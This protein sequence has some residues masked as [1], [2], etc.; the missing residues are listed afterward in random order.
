VHFELESTPDRENQLVAYSVAL[1]LWYESGRDKANLEKLIAVANHDPEMEAKLHVCLNPP[2]PSKEKLEHQEKLAK[3][4]RQHEEK[5]RQEQ[6]DRQTWIKRLQSDP[7]KLRE[8]SDETVESTFPDLYWLATELEEHSEQGNSKWGVDQWE[9]LVDEFGLE[10]A[11]A[12]RDGLM[13]YWRHFCPKLQS[14][15]NTN[16]VPNGLIVGMVGLAVEARTKADWARCLTQEEA[17]LAARYATHELNGFPLWLEELLRFHPQAVDGILRKEFLWE[18][19]LAD[20][21]RSEPIHHMLAQ[22]RYTELKSLKERYRP[23]IFQFL[24]NQE[25]WRDQTLENALSI[26]LQWDEL[27]VQAFANLAKQRQHATDEDDRFL[28][29]LVAWLCVDAGGALVVLKKWLGE[30]AEEIGG[31]ESAIRFCGAMEDHLSIRF[32]SRHQDF[33]RVEVLKELVPL[34]YQHIRIEDDHVH[35]GGYTPDARDRAES[36]RDRLLNKVCDTPGRLAFE[37]LMDFS[38]I[39]PHEKLRERML[40]LARHR[41][42]ED[43]EFLPWKSADV[44]AFA[45]EAEKCPATARELFDLVCSRL[46]DIKYDLEE[47]DNSNAD[48]LQQLSKETQLRNWLSDRLRKDARGKYSIAPEE[49]LADGKR[50]DIRVHCQKIDAPCVIELKISDEWTFKRHMERLRNQLVA[51]YLRD[52][53][54]RFGVFLLVRKRRPYWVSKQRVFFPDLVI[55]VQDEADRIVQGRFDLEGI[56]VIGIDLMKRGAGGK[57]R[58]LEQRKKIPQ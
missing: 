54:S 6:I 36:M 33:E 49:E 7:Q 56:R 23:V 18:F 27:D 24:Q 37:T 16:S 15:D 43:A 39:L 47:G 9:S 11:E 13:A 52:T 25:P 14:E 26:V 57:I 4:K 34:M 30:G 29:W 46:D 53:R 12:A 22:I 40:V 1:S 48:I 44:V 2:P 28:T 31:K 58:R 45:R 21:A 19:G 32:G 42:A 41:A 17:L 10:V 5:E 35:E 20:G 55:Q 38:R 51:Q 8:V 3:G 50:C